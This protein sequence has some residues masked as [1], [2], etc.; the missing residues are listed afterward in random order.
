[1]KKI[2]IMSMQRIANY[3]SFLQ[4]YG[5]KK[6]IEDLGYYVE[7]VDY[8]FEK[9]LIVPEKKRFLTKLFKN[10][11]IIKKLKT[12]HGWNIFQ[13]KYKQYLDKYFQ[14][15]DNK[16]NIRPKLDA[17]VI[18][19]DE[20]FN[21]MQSYP[22][23]YSRELFGKNYESTKVLSY[24]ASFGFTTYDML[25]EHNISNEIFDL[26][27]KFKGLSVRDANSI[28]I[29]HKLG[30][31]NIE[32][33]LDPVLISEYEI[34]N[35]TEYNNYIILYTYPGRLSHKEEVI[36]KKFAKKH[37][38]KILSLG[39]YQSIADINLYVDPFDVLGYF[40]SADFIITDTFHG[41]IFS[42]KTNNKFCTIVRKSNSNKLTHLLEKL[43]K[44]DR[45][46]SDLNDL[47]SFYLKDL[48]YSKTNKI[49]LE[50][51]KK[52]ID[53]LKRQLGDK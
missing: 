31:K 17:L 30:L 28:D 9:T 16:K 8:E 33:N 40:K 53:Y 5:L 14:I 50:E 18:G 32:L 4:A 6:T 10:I 24:A 13:K 15:K 35:I 37:N 36:I 38:K 21:C 42:I 27:S 25:L 47:E 1:M 23:G 3:G 7:F 29:L 46:I 51:K 44:K 45:I 41:S 11:N 12:R 22:V 49:I 20:V 43:D 34:S 48:D 19:S 26:L 39:F 2:G 52:S